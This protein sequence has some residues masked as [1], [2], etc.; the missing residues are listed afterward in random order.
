MWG[1]EGRLCR[2]TP[3]Q[4]AGYRGR[5]SGPI[6]DRIDLEVPVPPVPLSELVES[7][8][9][10]ERSAVVRGRVEAA[11]RL[12]AE[13]WRTCGAGTNSEVKPEALLTNAGIGGES[14][15]LARRCAERFQLSARAFHRLLRVART[16]AD[17]GESTDV[18][19]AHVA[20]AAA[21]RGQA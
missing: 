5:I 19:P 4:L 8:G 15:A 21:F 16:V 13:R 6:L 14:L 11:R 18:A 9:G 10:S 2:C 3:G 1:V 17:L 7:A 20:E 12:Q